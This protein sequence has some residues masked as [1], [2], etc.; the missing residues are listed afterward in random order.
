MG[1]LKTFLKVWKIK[2]LEIDNLI[3]IG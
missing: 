1:F 3:I 2:K